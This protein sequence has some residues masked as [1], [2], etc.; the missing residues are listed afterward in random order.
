MTLLVRFSAEA[1][2]ELDEAAAWYGSQAP[3]LGDSFIDAVDA[4]ISMIADW[5]RSGTPAVGVPVG[6]DVRRAPVARFPYHLAYMVTDDHVRIL[7]VAHD[8][9]RPNYWTPRAST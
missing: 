5:P 6:R 4:A 2:S 8:R 3:G 1:V 9:R 7:A